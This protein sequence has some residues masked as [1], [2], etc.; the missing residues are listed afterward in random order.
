MDWFLYVVDH[1]HERVCV[2]VMHSVY[3][4]NYLFEYKNE[5]FEIMKTM[6]AFV[7]TVNFYSKALVIF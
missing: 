2:H 5:D 4:A 1:R 7:K 6:K 3:F